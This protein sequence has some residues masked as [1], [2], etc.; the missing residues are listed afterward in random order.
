MQ[1]TQESILE[2]ESKVKAVSEEIEQIQGSLNVLNEELE[3]VNS[4][5]S[6]EMANKKTF[7]DKEKE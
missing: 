4:E 1:Q 5:K 3:K 2:H 7:L 6:V